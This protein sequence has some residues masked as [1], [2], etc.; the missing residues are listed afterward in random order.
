[1]ALAEVEVVR[2]GVVVVRQGVVVVLQEVEVAQ[3]KVGVDQVNLTVHRL[4]IVNELR[5]CFKSNLV[6]VQIFQ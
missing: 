6:A 4:Y 2:Q 1:M 3:Q 5:I